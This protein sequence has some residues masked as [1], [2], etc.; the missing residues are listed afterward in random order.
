MTIFKSTYEPF[1]EV[2]DNP[3]PGAYPID[4]NKGTEYTIPRAKSA[5][6]VRDYPGVGRYEVTKGIT[7]RVGSAIPKSARTNFISK[8]TAGVGDY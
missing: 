8:N 5:T 2:I 4:S 3:G 7:E 1:H 6:L